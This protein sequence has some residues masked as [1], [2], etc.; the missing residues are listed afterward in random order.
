M[1]G[2]YFY[3]NHF[4]NLIVG[5]GTLFN[6]INI[7]RIDAQ[8]NVIKTIEVPLAYGPKEKY[9]VRLAESTK[10]SSDSTNTTITQVTLPRI[11]FEINSMTYDPDRKLKTLGK[12]NK[13]PLTKVLQAIIILNGGGGYNNT[14]IVT[15]TGG[16]GTGATA[17]ATVSGGAVTSITIT[18]VGSGYT[19]NPTIGFTPTGG[20]SPSTTAIA[21]AK[22]SE[23]TYA[24]QPVPYNMDLSLNI[25]VKNNDDGNQILE[26]ILPFFTPEF[27]I[28]VKEIPP[29]GIIKDIPVILTGVTSTED[30]EG[31]FLGERRSIIH[32]LSFIMKAYLYGPIKDSGLIKE[33]TVNWNQDEALSPDSILETYN[34]I[35]DPFSAEADDNYNIIETITTPDQILEGRLYVT[36]NVTGVLT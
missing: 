15:I 4:R 7:K 34:A 10:I 31:D 11:S 36:I 21:T 35:V 5:F 17:T 1:L 29:L 3:H 32:T 20:D 22:I 26:Q 28:S 19:S 16:G 12:I 18:N 33:V 9:L 24:F 8:G 27:S 6:D 30:Y 13:V 2:K 14:P 23:I 25:M